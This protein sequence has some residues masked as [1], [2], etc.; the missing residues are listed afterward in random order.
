MKEHPLYVVQYEAEPLP[1]SD[2]FAQCS[3][4]FVNVWTRAAT[5]QE[6]L[7]IAA[8]EVQDA[9]WVVSALEAV[10]PTTREDYNDDASGLER[11][12]QAL[13]DGIVLVFHTWQEGTRH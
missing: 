11:Y 12:E 5:E 7:S 13:I 2:N 8:R 6:A 4:A 1:G 9:G 10:H 3:G